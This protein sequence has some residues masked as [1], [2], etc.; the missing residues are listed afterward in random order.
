MI[1]VGGVFFLSIYSFIVGVL[2]SNSDETT[3]RRIQSN[4][5][6]DLFRFF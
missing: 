3:L 2:I 5:R 4:N 1:P 6:D